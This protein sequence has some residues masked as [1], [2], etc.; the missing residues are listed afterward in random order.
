MFHLF[1]DGHDAR[2]AAPAAWPVRPA[3]SHCSRARP[4]CFRAQ[5]RPSSPSTGY[6]PAQPTRVLVQSSR[7]PESAGP[8]SST[9]QV[10]PEGCQVGQ[11]SVL[12]STTKVHAL[13]PGQEMGLGRCLLEIDG[14]GTTSASHSDALPQKK[15]NEK[16]RF[17][18]KTTHDTI[19]LK[20]HTTKACTYACMPCSPK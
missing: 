15:K 1:R 3:P 14:I 16:K 12:G 9:V 17:A 13:A 20:Q 8:Y 5:V 18:P 19:P 7:A 2:A 11:Y 6:T 10:G 4:R